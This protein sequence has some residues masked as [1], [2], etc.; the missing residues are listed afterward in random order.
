MLRGLALVALLVVAGVAVYLFTHRPAPPAGPNDRITIYYTKPDGSSLVSYTVTR[1]PASD[2][3]SI[4]FLAATQAVAGPPPD[5]DAIRFP[6][7]TF[8]RD[9][10]LNG[11]TAVVDLNGNVKN[12]GGGSLTEAGMFKSLVWTLTALHGVS[13]VQVKVDGMRVATLPDGHLEL[14]EPLQR[15]S[16]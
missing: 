11:P 13:E 15:S 3:H 8:V 5:V 9:V 6:S 1:G 2:P 16:W 4:A 7:G 12:T 14:D 10:E